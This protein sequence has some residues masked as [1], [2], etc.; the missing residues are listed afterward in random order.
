MEAVERA[1]FPVNR[2]NAVWWGG[3]DVRQETFSGGETGFHADRAGLE[4]VLGAAAAQ[5]GVAVLSP[6][7]ARSANQAPEGWRVRCQ[8]SEGSAFDVRG[9]WIVDATGR[10]GLLARSEGRRPD[11]GTATL[12]LVRRWHHPRGFPADHAGRTLIESY[13]EG[14][15]WSVPVSDDVRCVAAMV[16]GG[17]GRRGEASVAALLERELARTCRIGPGLAGAAPA[18][19]AWACPASLYTASRFGRPGLLLAGDAGSFID[20]LSSFGVKK[21]LS[22]GWLAAIVV[23]TALADPP[24]QAVAIDFFDRREAQVYRRYRGLSAE[25]FES[26]YAAYGTRY[27]EQ[28]ARAA[29]R[30]GG[31]GS[32]P[33]A[34]PAR[35]GRSAPDPLAD[36]DR[37]GA[38]IPEAS[39]RRAHEAIRARPSLDAAA[40]ASLRAV[41]R[42]AIQGHRIVL[43]EHLASDTCPEGMRWVRNVDLRCL[44]ATAPGHREVPDA[45]AAYN[46]AS[47]PVSLPDYLTALATAFAAGFL[48]HG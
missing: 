32:E 17:P 40:A 8:P 14:W 16:D 6:V 35:P 29:R 3:A 26:A 37:V 44:V 25:F 18:G 2:G 28:R 24:M 21:A 20:P 33:P 9:A 48:Q 45:W 4:A 12:A 30:A 23:H 19:E 36:P 47:T 1:G 13:E 42:P 5:A 31:T 22:S 41:D 7:T 11:R 15:A 10:H 46:G 43:Q 34:E 38:T 39:V 27:W